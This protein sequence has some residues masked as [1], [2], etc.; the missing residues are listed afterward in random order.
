MKTEAAVESRFLKSEFF[1]QAD[2]LWEQMGRA[3]GAEGGN[4]TGPLHHVR[5]EGAY[6][7]L[8]ATADQIFTHDLVLA[9]L[10][11]LRRWGKEKLDARRASTPQIHIYVEGCWRELAPDAVRIQWHYL[12]SLTRSVA[13]TVRLLEEDGAKK[14]H[15]GISLNRIA[16]LQLPFNHLLVHETSQAYA[17]DGPKRVTKP[18]EG[19]ILL[20]GYLG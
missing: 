3:L 13:P 11:R 17:L 6:S 14:K 4:G 7:F 5:S 1:E 18:L 8:L 15:F 10:N 9:F 19:T 16:N 12:Y 2:A 20:H